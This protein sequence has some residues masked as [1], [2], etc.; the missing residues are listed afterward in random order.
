MYRIL[1]FVFFSEAMKLLF[2]FFLVLTSMAMLVA[3]DAAAEPHAREGGRES[4]RKPAREGGRESGWRPAR[5]GGR[6][7]G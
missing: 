5:E 3:S 7:S 2:Y 1:I 4:G 6:E